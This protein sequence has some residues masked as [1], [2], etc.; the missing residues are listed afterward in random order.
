MPVY[1]DL[2]EVL[3]EQFGAATLDIMW[4]ENNAE[5]TRL[6]P[7]RMRE[8][9]T[10]LRIKEQHGFVGLK[11][12]DQHSVVGFCWRNNSP[13]W[14]YDERGLRK[15]HAYLNHFQAF[16]ARVVPR[17]PKN[18]FYPYNRSTT[19]TEVCYPLRVGQRAA[20]VLNLE[21]LDVVKPNY[22]AV[23]LLI[24]SASLIASVH[25][26]ILADQ[27]LSLRD[28]RALSD[29][30][31]EAKVH[32]IG[33]IPTAFVAYPMKGPSSRVGALVMKY[34]EERDIRVLVPAKRTNDRIM[35]QLEAD[36]DRCHFAVVVT[37]GF[38]PNVLFEWGYLR[39]AGKEI[40]RLHAPEN[41]SEHDPF[42]VAGTNRIEIRF[43]E[44][45]KVNEKSLLQELGGSIK[46]FQ[47]R[48]HHLSDLFRGAPG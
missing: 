16:E 44:Q 42:D 32:G 8:F 34:L 1:D 26:R 4:E 3:Q 31:E 7:I 29:A 13:I 19:K 46:L 21:F 27:T 33:V 47:Q 9:N 15:A 17:V 6:K 38:N 11:V 18:T 5:D 35:E 12:S 43:D 28:L 36:M 40:I 22:R 14:I 20:G 45:G 41:T 48:T 30:K 37:S 39:A 10:K 24:R 2:L 23:T 25:A